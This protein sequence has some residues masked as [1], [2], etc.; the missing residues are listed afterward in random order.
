MVYDDRNARELLHE[1]DIRCPRFE[2]YVDVM[3][4]YVREQQSA[5]R[6]ATRDEQQRA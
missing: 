1:L 4:D 3:V 6:A 2:S 5:R